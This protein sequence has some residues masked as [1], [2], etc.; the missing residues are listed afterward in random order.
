MSNDVIWPKF[1]LNFKHGLKIAILVIFQKSADWLDW[2]WPVSAAFKSNR[3][4][5]KI[6]FILGSYE[7][8]ER[9]EGKIRDGIFF[10]IN[11]SDN[12]SVVRLTVDMSHIWKIWKQ[13]WP[14]VRDSIFSYSTIINHYVLQMLIILQIK[15]MQ[16]WIIWPRLS[17][18]L[19]QT[20]KNNFS[21]RPQ[22]I[23]AARL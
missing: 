4:N 16:F 8:L 18:K 10:C 15:H 5:W 14:T 1:F 12:Y 20:L 13:R 7:Y 3:S 21:E 23:E 11:K 22:K 9:L 2:P 17:R 19:I 6:L